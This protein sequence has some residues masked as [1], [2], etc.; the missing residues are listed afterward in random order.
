MPAIPV[1]VRNDFNG[2][3]TTVAFQ[4][5]FDVPND[6]SQ[7]EV[8]LLVSD[9]DEFTVQVEDTDYTIDTDTKIVTFTTAPPTGSKVRIQRVT[10]RERDVDWQEAQRWTPSV[11]NRDEDQSFSFKQEIEADLSDCLRLNDRGDEWN[12]EGLEGGNAAPATKSDSWVTLAQVEAL[13]SDAEIVDLTDPI[14]VEFDGDGETLEFTLTGARSSTT[15]QWFVY[16]NGVHQNGNDVTGGNNVFTVQNNVGSDDSIIFDTAPENGARVLCFLLRGLVVSQ[17]GDDSLDGDEL[18][19][20]SIG[21]RHINVGAGADLRFLV[22]DTAGDPTARIIVHGDVSDFDTGVRQNRLDQMA[23]PEDDL[24]LNDVKITN[25]AAGTADEDAANVSQLPTDPARIQQTNIGSLALDATEV[26]DLGFKAKI[27]HV[28]FRY[29]TDALEHHA[30]ATAVLTDQTFQR[31]VYVA[32]QDD[33]S[34]AKFV[35]VR[36]NRNN[37]TGTKVH[38][39]FGATQWNLVSGL[40]STPQDI[41]VETFGDA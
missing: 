19:D 33:N 31:D 12:A 5:T 11:A 8:L 13:L 7:V 21:V 4:Y 20:D 2:D 3:G 17:I 40:H 16:K 29:R 37:S 28:S 1:T 30:S 10:E 24:D 23:V 18:Q 14:M 38:I 41:N 25:L 32:V 35:R 34:D 39:L 36:I 26:I 9:A 22:F 6:L 15:K 27:V